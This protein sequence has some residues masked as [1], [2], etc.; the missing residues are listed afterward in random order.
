MYLNF[1]MLNIN[2]MLPATQIT[3]VTCRKINSL[4]DDQIKN[5]FKQNALHLLIPASSSDCDKWGFSFSM[6]HLCF[7]WPKKTFEDVPLGLGKI[8]ISIFNYIL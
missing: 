6:I 4:I 3:S 2:L 1:K 5:V 7:D 8:I